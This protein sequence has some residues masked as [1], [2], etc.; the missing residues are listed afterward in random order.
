MRNVLLPVYD[1]NNIP[2]DSFRDAVFLYE[3]QRLTLHEA[4]ILCFCIGASLQVNQE[5]LFTFLFQ[6]S[7]GVSWWL[8]ADNDGTFTVQKVC[9]NAVTCI[10]CP[11]YGRT[12][13][14]KPEHPLDVQDIPTT[15]EEDVLLELRF[16]RDCCSF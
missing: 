11:L 13:D 15:E 16:E 6:D 4:S 10:L 12:C 3:G 1:R 14:G 2:L 5:T 7:N 9:L 8:Y